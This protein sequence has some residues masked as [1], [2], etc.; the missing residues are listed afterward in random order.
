[1]ES[2][3][4]IFF[5]ASGTLKMV[6]CLSRGVSPVL[7]RPLLSTGSAV[8]SPSGW[9]IYVNVRVRIIIPPAVRI[10]FIQLITVN[11]IGCIDTHDSGKFCGANNGLPIY[12]L[13]YRSNKAREKNRFISSE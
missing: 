6:L 7:T 2:I 11:I 10:Q 8:S 1:M 12:S 4:Y 3:L 5:I 13:A 9:P